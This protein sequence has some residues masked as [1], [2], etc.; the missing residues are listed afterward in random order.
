M[1]GLLLRLLQMGAVREHYV[2]GMLT[3]GPPWLARLWPPVRPHAV[4]SSKSEYKRDF[5]LDQGCWKHM[6]L[7]WSRKERDG[8]VVYCTAAVFEQVEGS[9]S[10]LRGTADPHKTREYVQQ[11]KGHTVPSSEEYRL[12]DLLAMLSNLSSFFSV[13]KIDPCYWRDYWRNKIIRAV[14]FELERLHLARVSVSNLI[15]ICLACTCW[16]FLGS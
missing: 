3:Q 5:I 8:R 12:A 10:F 2:L 6:H 9:F 15:W 11:Q 16:V 14:A 4:C 7:G 1:R 13:Q